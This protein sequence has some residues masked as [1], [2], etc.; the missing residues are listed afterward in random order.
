MATYLKSD[1]AVAAVM[2]RVYL[3]M[4]I[5]LGI[6]A[7]M[8][9]AFAYT[10]TL[11]DLLYTT[12]V[13]SETGASV[14]KMSIFGYVILFSPLLI[15]LFSRKN[16]M[17]SAQLLGLFLFIA[18]L[19]GASL[20]SIFLVYTEGS[21]MMALLITGGMFFVMSLYGFATKK[22]L[23]SWGSFLFMA[24]IGIIIAMLV[25]LFIR[26]TMIDYVISMIAVVVF[27]CMTAYDTQK[28]KEELGY[29]SDNEEINRVAAW[30]AFSLY[31]DF[32]NLLLHILRLFGQRK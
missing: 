10:P 4:F 1:T 9:Y 7:L 13:D 16:S 12:G 23:S 25:N 21:I 15:L 26:S 18:A 11:H 31:L 27:T 5:G 3:Y 29:S 32:I 2:R 14:T 6:S 22:N 8:A 28:I 17:N 20:S 24:L 30:G 19:M